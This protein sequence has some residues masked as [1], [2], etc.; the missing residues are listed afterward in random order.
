MSCLCCRAF[1]GAA[2]AFRRKVTLLSTALKDS[3]VFSWVY[4]PSSCLAIFPWSL[5]L[6]ASH[7]KGQQVSLLFCQ[8]T[9]YFHHS[10]LYHIPL[11][12]RSQE[13]GGKWNRKYGRAQ[14]LVSTL[15][16]AESRLYAIAWSRPQPTLR[17]FPKMPLDNPISS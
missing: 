7:P 12:L 6:P 13:S 10:F 16:S 8:I 11:G 2:L 5:S 4:L 3:T 14:N 9:F 1:L 15:H 17:I